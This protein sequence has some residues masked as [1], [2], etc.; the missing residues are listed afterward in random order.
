MKKRIHEHSAIVLGSTGTPYRVTTW[1]E[2]RRDGTWWGWLEFKPRT[3]RGRTL[4]TGQ[5]TTQ[6]SRDALAYW[7]SGLEMVY[8]EGAYRRALDNLGTRVLRSG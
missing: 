2:E 3:G 5:Q 7:A 1:G 8:M 4:R 6:P